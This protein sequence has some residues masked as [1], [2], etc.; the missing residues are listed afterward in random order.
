VD[1][2]VFSNKRL[3]MSTDVSSTSPLSALYT[4]CQTGCLALRSPSS[5]EAVEN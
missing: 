5:K 1:L 4:L 2:S 3:R